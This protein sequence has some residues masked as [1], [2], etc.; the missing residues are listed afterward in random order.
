MAKWH[1]APFVNTYQEINTST[2]VEIR[3]AFTKLSQ[4][5]SLPSSL[6][7]CHF[8]GNATY[9]CLDRMCCF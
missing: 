2:L 4:E 5:H 1:E 9:D 3:S 6:R 7:F 8:E